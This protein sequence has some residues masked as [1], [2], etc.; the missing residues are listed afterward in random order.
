MEVARLRAEL[1]VA[2]TKYNEEQ[3]QSEGHKR[4]VTLI[5]EELHDVK[6]K[7]SRVTQEKI[8][9]ERDQRAS[10]SLSKS[11]DNPGIT[12]ADLDFYKRKVSEL[13]GNVQGLNA[14]VAEKN[15]QIDEMRRQIERNAS[16][17]R[18]DILRRLSSTSKR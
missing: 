7:L 4:R 15:R 16:K 11:L 18:V 17:H 2:T 8:R 14:V 12:A 9:M 10:L 6:I 1:N 13:N 5:Q 3:G